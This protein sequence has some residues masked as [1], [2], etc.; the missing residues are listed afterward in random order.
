VLKRNCTRNSRVRDFSCR[1][2]IFTVDIVDLSSDEKPKGL[3]DHHMLDI[4]N[5]DKP[6]LRC[7]LANNVATIT[8]NRP[9]KLNAFTRT[10]SADLV[11]LIDR[12][13]SDDAIRAIIVTGEGRAFCAGA[14]LA[15][16]DSAVASSS[17]NLGDPSGAV[18][19]DG[20]VDWS[21]EGVRDFGGRITLRIFDSL[22]P[23][24]F[25][26]N[27]PAAGMGVTMS[28]AADIRIAST[29]S[30]FSLPFARRGIVPESASSWFLPRIVGI[31]R[32]LEWTMT[33]RTF[34]AIE[35]LNGGLVRSLH[36]PSELL[37]AAVELA[38]EIAENAAPVSVALTRQLLWRMLGEDHPMEAHRIESR[39]VFTRTRSA[40][41]REGVASFF[42][43]R[44]PRFSDRVSVDMPAFF[45]WWDE[46]RY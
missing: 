21:H 6:Y 46:R 39:G 16:P 8:F 44:S 40:D 34:S 42:E 23:V 14:D 27:G 18:Q 19:P 24:I 3:L 12:L 4:Q 41:M 37:P 20:S 36:E 10:M 15:A 30:K 32:A 25:A 22:K 9:E 26:I 7:E 5:F 29:T 31:S 28:L 45:P 1:Q 11:E 35:A 2:L 43:K 33:G 13:D 38:R 17:R